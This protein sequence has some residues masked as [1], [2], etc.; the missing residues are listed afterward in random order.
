MNYDLKK[1]SWHYWLAKIGGQSGWDKSTNLCAYIRRIV[2]GIIKLSFWT[3]VL[4]MVT[5]AYFVG[6]WDFFTCMFDASCTEVPPTAALFVAL[7]GIAVFLFVLGLVLIGA[8]KV[9][10][11]RISHQS[12]TKEPSFLTLVYRKF[13]DKTCVKINFK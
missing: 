7:S 11:Y 3:I 13:K 8:D 2:Y 1:N 12:V 6:G 10:E 4:T 5:I 9:R